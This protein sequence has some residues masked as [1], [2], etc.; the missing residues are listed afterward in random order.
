MLMFWT[1]EGTHLPLITVYEPEYL[2]ARNQ[3]SSDDAKDDDLSAVELE[4]S[5][6]QKAETGTSSTSSFAVE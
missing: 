6:G 5:L 2:R 3:V 4:A 1:R